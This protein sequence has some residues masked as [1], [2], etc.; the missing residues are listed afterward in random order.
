MSSQYLSVNAFI[1]NI[2]ISPVN[3]VK[4]VVNCFRHNFFIFDKNIQFLTGYSCIVL[5][6]CGKL[7][8]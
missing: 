7:K 1:L 8:I 2:Y 6:S 4:V 5:L 3:L